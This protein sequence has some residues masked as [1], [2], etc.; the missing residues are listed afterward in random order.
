MQ[1]NRIYVSHKGTS[2]RVPTF[3]CPVFLWLALLALLLVAGCAGPMPQRTTPDPTL[4]IGQDAYALCTDLCIGRGMCREVPDVNGQMQ[5]VIHTRPEVGGRGFAL[6][7]LATGAQVRLHDVV[8]NWTD[9]PADPLAGDAVY[10]VSSP[11]WEAGEQFW[12]PVYCLSPE[13]PE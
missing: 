5:R 12:V 1:S 8:V 11:T 7:V 13:P 3:Q 4:V 9:D 2:C 6:K 10:L